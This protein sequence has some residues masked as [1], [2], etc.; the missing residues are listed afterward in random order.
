MEHNELFTKTL[1]LMR[2]NLENRDFLEE[3]RIPGHFVRERKLTMKKMI[4]Y[5]LYNAKTTLDN[6]LAQLRENLPA[7][8]MPSVSRQAISKARYGIRCELFREL[9]DLNVS[10]Y[11]DNIKARKCWKGKYHPFAIDGSDLE[12]PSSE[13]VFE[14]FGKQSD[15]KNPDLFWSM[16]LASTMYD[17]LEDIIVDALLVKQFY[18]EREL[19]VSHLARLSDLGLQE[20]CVVIFDRGYFCEDIYQ[21]CVN[22]GCF[23]LMRLRSSAKLCRLDGNDVI[24][25]IKAPDN[26][27][28][29]CR[30]LKVVL[31]TGETEYLVTNVMDQSLTCEDFREL[32]FERWKIETKYLEFKERWEIEEFSGTGVLAVRQDFYITMLHANLASIIKSEADKVIS[33]TS[34]SDNV[35]KYQARR[36]YIIEKLHLILVKWIITSFSQSDVEDLI[37]DVSKKRSQFQPG[38]TRK[39]RRR[40]RARKH[41]NNQKSAL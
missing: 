24:T 17:V 28:M 26:T 13:S 4:E 1:E 19:A 27:K 8:E 33:R 31:S 5:L 32:Y 10:F 16:A 37:M 22:T 9:F 25:S 14:E 12:V 29:D 20:N 39:R 36:T 38:R 35:Y 40:T 2:E 6:R 3:F 18:S 7:L 30:V 34:K 11:Y 15:Q 41:Y 21:E 23:C